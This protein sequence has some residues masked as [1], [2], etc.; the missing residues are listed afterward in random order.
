MLI[1]ITNTK[2]DFILTFTQWYTR[3][4]EYGIKK[5]KKKEKKGRISK[6]IE[7]ISYNTEQKIKEINNFKAKKRVVSM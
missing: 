6:V 3:K 7:R 5:E 2:Q 1:N 4:K